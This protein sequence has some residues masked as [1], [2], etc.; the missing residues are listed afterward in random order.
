MEYARLTVE[1]YLFIAT[2]AAAFLK[3]IHQ[4]MHL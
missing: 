2:S 1:Y 3:T 4:I